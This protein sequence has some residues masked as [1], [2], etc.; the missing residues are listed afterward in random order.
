[1]LIIRFRALAVK[2]PFTPNIVDG[3]NFLSV[4]LTSFILNGHTK[5]DKTAAF[6][7]Q[8]KNSTGVILNAYGNKTFNY[9][10]NYCNFKFYLTSDI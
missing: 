1:M 4:N 6:N 2:F 9:V 3:I 5:I 10:K 7:F 8:N